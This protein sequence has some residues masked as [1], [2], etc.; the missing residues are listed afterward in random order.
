[1]K[2]KLP[3]LDDYFHLRTYGYSIDKPEKERHE[4]LEKAIKSTDVLYVLRRLNL[5][6]NLQS[7]GK[8]KKI[9]SEDVEYL[10]K[11]KK[12]IG[13][14]DNSN[15]PYRE[16]VIK[17]IKGG[18]LINIYESHTI[19]SIEITF[20][21][22]TEDDFMEIKKFS[23]INCNY[24][25]EEKISEYINNDNYLFIGLKQESLLSGITCIDLNYDT[26][27]AVIVL[28]C[29]IK[30]L[31]C[32]LNKFI[33]KIIN[34]IGFEHI[35]IELNLLKDDFI[36]NLNIVIKNNYEAEFIKDNLIMFIKKI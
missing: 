32:L 29:T 25:T 22:L 33:E 11:R 28:L 21:S 34:S 13:L 18:N 36:K 15:I 17:K 12:E 20:Y 1:M 14:I 31:T 16:R 19:N 27:K 4:A 6:R 9:M 7:F 2:T 5:A 24:L 30:G 23:E 10:K 35:I 3:Q 26:K 8:A